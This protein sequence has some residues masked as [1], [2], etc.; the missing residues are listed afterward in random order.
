ML[1]V[2]LLKHNSPSESLF[3]M[4]TS[5][6]TEFDLEKLFLPAWAQEAPN[7]NKYAS[8]EG[9]DRRPRTGDGS[10]RGVPRAAWTDR[11]ANRARLGPPDPADLPAKADL[12]ATGEIARLIRAAA[13]DLH[14][15]TKLRARQSNRL[16]PR[17][18]LT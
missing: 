12:K 1:W 3:E 10:A 16:N 17:P 15:R 5:P 8:F 9:E 13:K 14:A 7:V 18:T 11:A 6:E 4:S 2:Q